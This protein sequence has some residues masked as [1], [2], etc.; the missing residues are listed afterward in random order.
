M[1][2]PAKT[3]NAAIV[4]A[5]REILELVGPDQFGLDDVARA[6]GVRTPSLYKRFFA[7]ASLLAALEK[8]GF[9]ELAVLLTERNRDDDHLVSMANA[10][11]DFARRSP[12]LYAR[13]LAPDATRTEES[14]QWRRAAVAPV[15]KEIGT[16]VGPARAL[17]AARAVTAFLHGFVSMESAGAFR[18]GG[19]IDRDF[20][21]ALRMVLDGIVAHKA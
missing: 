1:A 11:R 17:T 3:S 21:L 9:D 4:T 18:L 5:A 13:M 8:H 20:A 19:H 10:Y 12:Q 14:E 16:L 2:A 6:V 15:L 7:R